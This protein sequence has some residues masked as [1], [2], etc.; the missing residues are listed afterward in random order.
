MWR[1]SRLKSLWKWVLFEF[2]MFNAFVAG[3]LGC[4]WGC[5]KLFSDM[6]EN[7]I[8]GLLK[9]GLG[10]LVGFL[11]MGFMIGIGAIFVMGAIV[12]IEIICGKEPS[13]RI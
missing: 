13:Y 10:C 12:N 8:W 6:P 1:C 4:I 5:Y 11:G 7:P 9:G 3:F 2:V